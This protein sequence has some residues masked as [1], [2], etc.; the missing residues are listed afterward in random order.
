[1][2]RTTLVNISQV[3][4]VAPEILTFFSIIPSWP[5]KLGLEEKILYMDV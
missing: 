3:H 4:M 2:M 5:K 1:M